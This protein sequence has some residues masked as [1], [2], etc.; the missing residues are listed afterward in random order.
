V[1]G[2]TGFIGS[3]LVRRLVK[4][5]AKLHL[6]VREGSQPGSLAPIWKRLKAH[7]GDLRDPQ[8]LLEGVRRSKPH[9]AFHLAKPR[10]ATLAEEVAGTLGLAAALCRQPFLR[11]W[12]RT[13]HAVRGA[14]GRGTD[15]HLARRL[16]EHYRLPVV[17][18][19]LYQVYGPGQERSFPS[20]WILGALEG[21]EPRGA[22]RSWKDFVYVDD[23]VEAY[24]LAATRPGVEGRSFQIGSGVLRS[25]EEA[26]S[27][28]L[29]V[30]GLGFD[31][32]SPPVQASEE[33]RGHPADISQAREFL[34][35]EPRVSWET[36]LRRSAAF[37]RG[38]KSRGRPEDPGR[39]SLRKK[40]TGPRPAIP[41]HR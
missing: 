26:S 18:L 32:E 15:G 4:E 37:F 5:G 25:Q 21:Q 1:T 39:A 6:L 19:E 29:G 28:I 16:A 31:G 34:G 3:H 11:R 30:L 10:E 22:G 7:P 9:V 41:V 12:V 14:C 13:A 20:S 27:D 33:D 35:W 24:L 8:S 36:G 40:G 38:R 23:V 17:T 2:G